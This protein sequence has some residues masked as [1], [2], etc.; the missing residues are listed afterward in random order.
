MNNRPVCLMVA[1]ANDVSSDQN[2]VWGWAWQLHLGPT[3]VQ[4]IMLGYTE[5]SKQT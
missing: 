2:L 5:T 3:R 1:D 4:P